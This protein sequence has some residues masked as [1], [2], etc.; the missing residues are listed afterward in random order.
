MP[1]RP[2]VDDDELLDYEEDDHD[3]IQNGTGVGPA[4]NGAAAAGAG[5]DKDKKNQ[6]S[7][8]STGFR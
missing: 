2:T 1:P 6:S 5:D 4:K 8:H 7:I 3:T